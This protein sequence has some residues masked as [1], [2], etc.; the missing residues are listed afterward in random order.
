M[1]LEKVAEEVASREE[2]LEMKHE[3]SNFKPLVN[4]LW[5]FP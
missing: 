3:Q 1:E 5:I 4:S 2:Y